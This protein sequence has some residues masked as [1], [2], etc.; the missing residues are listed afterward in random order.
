MTTNEMILEARHRF[1]SRTAKYHGITKAVKAINIFRY[2]EYGSVSVY[3]DMATDKII[4]TGTGYEDYDVDAD[5][6]IAI[7]TWNHSK[8]KGRKCMQSFM[9]KSKIV[10]AVKDEY[11]HA[12]LFEGLVDN[13]D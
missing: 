1:Y 12:V 13:N 6:I 4:C 9:L 2:W 5:G 3:Y 11:D 7:D 8:M 10:R